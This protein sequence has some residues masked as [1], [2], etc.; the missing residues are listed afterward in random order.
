MRKYA[1][2]ICL[3]MIRT[4]VLPTMSLHG[5]LSD[6]N[7]DDLMEIRFKFEGFLKVFDDNLCVPK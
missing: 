2:S 4:D 3:V 6:F 1:F 7:G 5:L